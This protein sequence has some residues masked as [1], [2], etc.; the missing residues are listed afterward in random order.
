MVGDRDSD[1]LGGHSNALA[2]IGVTY[3]FGSL[4]ELQAA[5]S[6]QIIASPTELP[7]AVLALN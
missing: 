3:G 1:I 4:A 7:A 2:G 6:E 5:K